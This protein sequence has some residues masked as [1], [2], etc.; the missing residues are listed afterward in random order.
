MT[1]QVIDARL[2]DTDHAPTLTSSEA[3]RSGREVY[4]TVRD[5]GTLL[6]Q[7]LLADAAVSGLTGLALAG[8][9]PLAALVFGLSTALVAGVGAF[10]IIYGAALGLLVWR[11]T[12]SLAAARTVVGGNALWVVASLAFLLVGPSSLTMLG[13]G[14]VVMQAAAVAVLAELQWAGLRRASVD[15]VAA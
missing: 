12:V 10:F 6:R 13:K 9:A 2:R 7:A 1:S 14:F 8:G 3:R 5:T 11:P 15:A 4:M